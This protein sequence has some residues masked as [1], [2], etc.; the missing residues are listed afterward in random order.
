MEGAGLGAVRKLWLFGPAPESAALKSGTLAPRAPGILG[1]SA[2]GGP[3][4]ALAGSPR[5]LGQG[6]QL[7]ETHGY[8]GSAPERGR[9]SS[10]RRAFWAILFQ[11]LTPRLFPRGAWAPHER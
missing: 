11:R 3:G 4:G 6:K 7:G 1:K 10:L 9:R 5:G 8:G 2:P